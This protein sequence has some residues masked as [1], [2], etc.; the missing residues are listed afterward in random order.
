[1]EDRLRRLERG[2]RFL[3]VLCAAGVLAGL[4]GAGGGDRKLTVRSLELVDEGG[5]VRA[6]L[7]LEDGAPVFQLADAR[8]EAR[9]RLFD[10]A[11]AIGM[12]IMDGQGT[13]RIGVARFSHAGGGV[14]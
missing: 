5:S 9:L 13:A 1:V 11:D 12:T 2:N 14:A 8:G 6:A 7:F 10:A 3:P 4:A